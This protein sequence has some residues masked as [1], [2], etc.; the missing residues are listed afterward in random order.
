MTKPAAITGDYTDIRFIKGRKVAVINIEIPIEAAGAFVEAFGTPNPATGVPVAIARLDPSAGAER[1]GGKLAQQ[2]GII[3]QEPAFKKFIEEKYNELLPCEP[4]DFV[5][6][7]CG[8]L[9]RAELDHH[10]SAGRR[11]KDVKL[12]YE[13][14]KVAA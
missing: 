8:V 9:S 1:K 10:E 6:H 7:M 13:A 4:A 11:F 14:W 2:A 12:E 5:R 3:C